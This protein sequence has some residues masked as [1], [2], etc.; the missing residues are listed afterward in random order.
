ELGDAE[1]QV[2]ATGSVVDFIYIF[3]QGRDHYGLQPEGFV[4]R[5]NGDSWSQNA[6]DLPRF[7][8]QPFGKH[9]GKLYL[10]RDGIFDFDYE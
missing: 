10:D 5:P 1:V 2:K 9:G 4:I 3:P 7:M 8:K 6:S